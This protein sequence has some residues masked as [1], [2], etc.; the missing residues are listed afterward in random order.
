MKKILLLPSMVLFFCSF[1]IGQ[2]TIT[3][4]V[5]AEDGEALI[6]ATILLKGTTIGTTTDIDGTYSI[7]VGDQKILL[8]SYTGFVTKEV[9]ISASNVIDVKMSEGLALNEVVVTALGI[10]RE[11]KSLGYA[12][13]QIEGTELSSN[14]QTNFVQSLSG[15]VSG[16]NIRQANAM[17]G[18]AN[19]VIRGQKSLTNNNQALYVVDGVPIDNGHES[20]D[21]WG[22]Y[23]YGNAAMDINP[24][25]IE[26]VSILKGAA[27]TALYGSR[28]ANGVVSITTKKGSKTNGIGVTVNSNFVVGTI[29][30][31]TMPKHQK[32]YGGGYGPF[33][34]DPTSNFF[35]ADIDGD[36]VK[37][38]IAPTSEDASW[39]AKFDPNLQVIHW[40]ALDPAA[41]NYGEKRPW[42]AGANGIDYFF[43]DSRKFT[44]TVTIDGSNT[45]GFFRLS[46]TNMDETGILPNSK[47]DR[48]TI[49]FGAGYDLNDKLTANFHGSYIKNTATGRY[50]TGYDGKNVMQSFS[51][52]IQTNVDFQRLEE[53]WLRPDGSQLSWNHGYYDD[54]NPIYFDNPYWVRN[55]NYQN[56]NRDRT[57]G[58]FNLV[59]KPVEWLSITGRVAADSYSETRSERTA[60]GSVDQSNFNIIN[61]K[62]LEVNTDLIARASKR[63]N[64]LTVDVML[65][66]NV[67]DR[68]YQSVY[69]TTVGGLII[70]DYYSVKNSI[71]PTSS[72]EKLQLRN[73]Y[74]GYGSVTLGYKGFAYL[75][76]TDRYDVT[77]TLPRA[78]NAYNY[79]SISGSF[80]L[81][82]LMENTGPLSYAK[83]RASYGEVGNDAA[84]Y[85]IR[86]V[87]SQAASFGTIPIFS[88]NNSLL[89]ADLRPERTKS[90]EL[91]L[92]LKFL[93]NRIGLDVAVYKDNSYDQIMPVTVSFA[94]G[95]STR[96][97]NGGELEN[98]GVEITLNATPVAIR[99]FEWGF[100]A[101]WTKN[102]NKVI[103][104]YEGNQNLLI[105]SAWDAS[106][107][108]TVGQPYGT[109]RGTNFLYTNGQRTV[110][111]NGY[112]ME[113]TD[114]NGNVV[115][116]AVLGD[117]NPDWNMGIS[118]KLK[119]KN[120]TISGLLDIQHGGDIYSINTKYGQA[121]GVFAE[122][123]GL[124]DKGNPIRD[125]VAD[126]GGIKFDAVK[127][128]GS[129]NDIY[130]PAYRWGRAFYYNNS[131]TARYVLDASYVKFRELVIS[132]DLPKRFLGNAPIAGVQFSLVGRNLAILSKNVEHFDP[133]YSA[134]SGNQQGIES[135]AYPTTKSYGFNIRLQF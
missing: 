42:V 59:Y 106:I 77:S 3:G 20:I 104:L 133:E 130:T 109:I 97:V 113:E 74:S 45:A 43:K 84:P 10:S 95:N 107:N 88:V 125:R 69:T 87:Y 78:N 114:A 115:S 127:A 40:D 24:E 121:T 68:E 38:L 89:N 22:G 36:G 48:N 131:P 120:L 49:T 27:A 117:I 17:G 135:G 11:E 50:G 118:T 82:E 98:K 39:G 21:A 99:D 134:A 15:K 12:V 96:W 64:D 44:N 126:G 62:V 31:S 51:Q 94:S 58:Q 52:W 67:R 91:G 119:Y 55:K 122:T 129:P 19:V 8:F 29:D 5:T 1:A 75:D 35:Y 93:Q 105:Y 128:D 108:A 112:F 116:D 2:R 34:E 80:I 66:G 79:Y 6:G 71:S 92:E 111:E 73:S 100:T 103:S 33:Y 90:S 81:S 25:D 46:F 70:P 63:F 30:N 56:D 83:I 26:S 16:V 65:G 7:E 41:S 132:Y 32:E 9:A 61:A 85:K 23:D 14:P 123:A 54:L 102:K 53:K 86:N 57:L 124:N 60:I 76:F 110:D 72:T 47:M 37:D 4:S 13:Q 18:S 101:N 28:A